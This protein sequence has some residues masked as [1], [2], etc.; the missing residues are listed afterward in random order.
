MQGHLQQSENLFQIQKKSEKCLTRIIKIA[1]III[2]K[3]A[4]KMTTE[5]DHTAAG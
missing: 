2:P 3:G 4:L 5:Y 1:P